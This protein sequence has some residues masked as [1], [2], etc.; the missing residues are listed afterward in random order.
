MPG[1]LQDRARGGLYRVVGLLL[2]VCGAC[3]GQAPHTSAPAAGG[4][5]GGGGLI[6]FWSDRDWPTLWAMWADGSHERRVYKTYQNAKRPT[7]SPDGRWIAFDGDPPGKQRPLG[8][9]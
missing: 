4:G 9:F 7:P 8:D 1:S 6:Y 3:T 2:L 5:V